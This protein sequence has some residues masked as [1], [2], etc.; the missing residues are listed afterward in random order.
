MRG[1]FISNTFDP[2]KMHYITRQKPGELL[3]NGGVV[4]C[5]CLFFFWLLLF[6]FLI[7]MFSFLIF[8]KS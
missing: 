1:S 8:N 5:F 7:F 2:S 3:N 6:S 4:L